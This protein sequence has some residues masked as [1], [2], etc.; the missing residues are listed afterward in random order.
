LANKPVP[1]IQDVA[2]EA[3]VS[4]ST[5]SNV[6]NRRSRQ[7]SPETCERILAVAGRLNYQPNAMAAALRRR[8]TRTIGVVVTNILS[9]FFTAVVRGVQDQA[10][11][12]GYTTILGN[13]D[14]DPEQEREILTTFRA[15]QVDGMIVVTAGGNHQTIQQVHD[16]GVPVVLVDRGDPALALDT[17]R[18]DNEAAAENAVNYLLDLGH[19]R[20]AIISGLTTGVPTRAGRLT[21]YLRAQAARGIDVREGYRQI[22]VSSIENGRLA[23][24]RLLDRPEPP[25]AMVPTNTFLAIGAIRAIRQR[26]LRIPG[27]ISFL[28]FDDPDWATIPEA[29]FTT[30][31]QPIQEIAARAFELLDAR[32]KHK[33]PAAP[34]QD[35]IFPT[36][37]IVRDSCAAP[38]PGGRPAPPETAPA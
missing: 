14:D 2:R 9:P 25:T 26:G 37:L 38:T 24:E 21:G 35:V 12:A 20:I 19:R 28:M 36:S 8:T 33:R 32:M 17:V 30:V 13:T 5:V 22:V 23:A 34:P 1:T 11:A 15:K 31:A 10:R 4:A 27:D 29:S 6:L 7:T 16:S 3:G 18:V